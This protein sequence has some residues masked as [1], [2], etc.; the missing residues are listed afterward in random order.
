[1][2]QEAKQVETLNTQGLAQTKQRQYKEALQSFS[3]AI[4]LEPTYWLAYYNRGNVYAALK[5]YRPAMADFAQVVKLNPK[6]AQAYLNLGILLLN[7]NDLV[8]AR[9]CFESADKLGHPKAKNYLQQMQQQ[10]KPPEEAP[11]APPQVEKAAPDDATALIK[12]GLSLIAKQQYATAM[13]AFKQV[14][15]LDSEA[16]T[17]Y[18]G[19]GMVYKAEFFQAMT[20]LKQANIAGAV[21][22]AEQMQQIMRQKTAKP[23][24]A[25]A[26]PSEPEAAPAEKVLAE[27]DQPQE[28]GSA[29]PDQALKYNEQGLTAM[30]QGDYEAALAH[31]NQAVELDPNL[32]ISYSHRSAI[33]ELLQRFDEAL[34]DESKA[35][36]LDPNRAISYYN[37]SVLYYQAKNFRDALNDLR[38]AIE[39]D[40]N[41]APAYLNLG[42]IYLEIGSVQKALQNFDQ[43]AQLGNEQAAQYAAELRQALSQS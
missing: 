38:K 16:I 5:Q 21:E 35:I 33:Y 37:R 42:V 8:K 39:L 31:F 1:M 14:L 40:P 25:E 32:A 43:G 26:A 22:L 24:P 17:R 3:Q 18:T 28:A 30:E 9:H 2:A 36:E 41:L 15:A 19:Q 12:E 6:H 10:P 13:E 11:A 4:K 20:N 27:P 34:A 7:Q 29:D 23:A